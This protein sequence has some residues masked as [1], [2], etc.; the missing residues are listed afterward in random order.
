MIDVEFGKDN[1]LDRILGN[2][3]AISKDA[4]VEQSSK[5][6][7]TVRVAVRSAF[8]NEST[9]WKQR[10]IENKKGDTVRRITKGGSYGLGHRISHMKK[11]N[12]TGPASMVNFI[13][14]HTSE[15]TGTTTV[16]GQFSKGNVILRRDGKIVGKKYQK[17]I[18]KYTIAILEKLNY[19]NTNGKLAE[20]IRWGREGKS[21][22]QGSKE[23][24]SQFKDKW[25]ARHFFE[26]GFSRAR[27]AVMQN[28]TNDLQRLIGK[29]ANT[30][31]LS[32]GRMKNAI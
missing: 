32:Q 26:Q 24:I 4:V 7:N 12:T 28:M 8:E 23:S 1:E 9:E 13:Q 3:Y 5:A 11:Q 15:T 29:V 6:G 10:Y 17:G 31:D 22:K 19:G 25:K 30:T 20:H 18:S 2:F 16:G 21:G 14:S 27:G